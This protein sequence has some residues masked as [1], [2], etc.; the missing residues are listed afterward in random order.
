MI[1]K[2]ILAKYKTLKKRNLLNQISKFKSQYAFIGVGSHSLDNLYPVLDYL[3]I[4]LKY[5]CSKRLKHA[6][7]LSKKYK[8][9]PVNNILEVFEDKEVDGVFI[10]YHPDFHYTIALE[11]LEAGKHVFVE[12]PPCRNLNELEILINKAKSNNL[13]FSVGFQRKYSPCYKKLKRCLKD[14][15]FYDY[16]YCIGLYPEGNA[17]IELFI[18]SL[19]I[20][21]YLFGKV[22]TFELKNPCSNTFLLIS[23]HKS[24]VCGT[25]TLSTSHSW[26]LA[27]E[28]LSVNTKKGFYNL[29]YPD[30]LSFTATTLN[31]A[32]VPFEKIIQKP[33][34]TK[35]LFQA[36]SFIPVG[37]NNQIYTS[38]YYNEL[39]DFCMNVENKNNKKINNDIIETYKWISEINEKIKVL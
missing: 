1:Y 20:L 15:L 30:N 6:K 33:Q 39:E 24:G 37:K 17:I 34:E 23:T 9:L 19:N 35:I 11:A 25:I 5:I 18:H 3:N 32:G 10:S 13:V 22:T 38:G 16:K 4:S 14:S 27:F 12:K 31:I 36:N 26:H 28:T 7:I 2:S 8:T 29:K 21:S